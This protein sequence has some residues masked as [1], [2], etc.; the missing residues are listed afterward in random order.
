MDS[1]AAPEDGNWLEINRVIFG[2][3]QDQKKPIASNEF[4]SLEQWLPKGN[5]TSSQGPRQ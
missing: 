2:R 5:E 3:D 4:G 1:I